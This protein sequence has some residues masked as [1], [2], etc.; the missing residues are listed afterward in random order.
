MV[1][2]PTANPHAKLVIECFQEGPAL[3]I[4]GADRSPIAASDPKRVKESGWNGV[5]EPAVGDE[6][7]DHGQDGEGIDAPFNTGYAESNIPPSS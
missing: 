1:P 7:E 4:R 6:K 5:T 3:E 2:K